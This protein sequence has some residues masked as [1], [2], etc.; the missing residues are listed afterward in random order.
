MKVYFDTLLIILGTV[1]TLSNVMGDESKKYVVMQSNLAEIK[2]DFN[3]DVDR[4]RLLFIISP[5]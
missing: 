4:V 5:T 2:S 3:K 1:L